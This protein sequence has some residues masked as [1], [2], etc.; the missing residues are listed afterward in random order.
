MHPV[1]YNASLHRWQLFITLTFRSK[2]G[3]GNAVKV[4]KADER[5]K[6][7]FAFL[8]RVALGLKRSHKGGNRIEVIPFGALLWV[9]REERGELNGRHHFHILLDGLPPSR[10]N[11]SERFAI[12]A[13]WSGL[14]GGHSDVRMFDTRL[15]GVEYVMK[16]LAG[17]R[18]A[19]ANS[20]ELRKFDDSHEDKSLILANSCVKKW[21]RLRIQ[22]GTEG[23]Q[24]L[25]RAVSPVGRREAAMQRAKETTADHLRA[26][27]GLN[28][29]PAGVSFVR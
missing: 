6:M 17:W 7:L 2:D 18:Q 11:T 26:S 12:K 16:G 19:N 20:Y 29:H 10:L 23:T 8:R 5:Q 27:Y 13:I 28:M 24:S 14:G 3:S 4:P 21:A 25:I 9:A 1:A 22:G 15:P